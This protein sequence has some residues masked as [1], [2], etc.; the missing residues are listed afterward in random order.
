MPSQSPCTCDGSLQVRLKE[1][2]I[3]LKG[4]TPKKAM[5]RRNCAIAEAWKKACRTCKI[6]VANSEN[7]SLMENPLK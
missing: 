6:N 4:E 2:I 5:Y 1:N 7:Y 3:C